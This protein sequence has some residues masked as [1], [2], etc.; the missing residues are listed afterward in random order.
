MIGGL[1]AQ[2]A[3]ARA[4]VITYTDLR[5]AIE[6]GWLIASGEDGGRFVL[7]PLARQALRRAKSAE[8]GPVPPQGS[9]RLPKAPALAVQPAAKPAVDPAES[10]LAWLRRHKDK[11]GRPL[12]SALQ[13]DAGERLRADF[14]QAAMGPRVTVDWSGI[15]GGGSGGR[16]T[17]NHT[18]GVDIRDAI[19]SAQQRVRRA[20]SGVGPVSAGL[21]IDVC[22]H[23][24]GLEE[25]ERRRGW[26][27]RSGKIALQL[28]LSELAR[29][30]RLPGS[31]RFDDEIVT[32]LR[33]WGADGYRPVVE[34]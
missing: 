22:G 2:Q 24:V 30:Y 13:F 12:I 32:R 6:V 7:S 23:L 21:L 20:L 29:H 5:E 18:A 10:P 15:G 25:I 17:G 1:C 3:K 34:R 33:H 8:G 14:H 19:A 4:M 9:G 11:S 28:A 16:S 26:P 31:E 27:V